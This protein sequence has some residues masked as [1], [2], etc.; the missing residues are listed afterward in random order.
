MRT[1]ACTRHMATHVFYT[2]LPDALEERGFAYCPWC[3]AHALPVQQ[4]A[5]SN[6]AVAST[7]SGGA[8]TLPLQ[9]AT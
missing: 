1:W 7:T 8:R 5:L 6:A 2:L 4:G 9:R 3:K